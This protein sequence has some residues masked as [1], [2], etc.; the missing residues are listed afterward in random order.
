MGH[1][2]SGLRPTSSSY[3]ALA[4]MAGVLAGQLAFAVVI[5]TLYTIARH[6]AGLLD[7]DR[8]VTFDNTAL[9]AWYAAGQSLLGLL[10]VHGFP[11]AVG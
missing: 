6:V 3:G 5:M 9:L 1:W 10:L 8:R 2:Q 7:R 4:F 11:R